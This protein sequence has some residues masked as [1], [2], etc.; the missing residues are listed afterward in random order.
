MKNHLL[1]KKLINISIK[2]KFTNITEITILKMERIIKLIL[3][4]L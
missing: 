3:Q 4:K 1:S 2:L